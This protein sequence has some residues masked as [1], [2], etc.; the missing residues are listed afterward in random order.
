[1][2]I[3]KDNVDELYARLKTMASGRRPQFDAFVSYLEKKTVWLVSPASTRFHLSCCKGLLM[4]S[5]G[6]AYQLLTIKDELLPSVDD[7]SA[8]I[9]G[10]F[11]DVG[12]LGDPGKPLYLKGMENYYYNPQVVSMGLGVRGLYLVSQ[13]IALSPDEAQAICCHDGQYI[14][15]NE[16]VAHR[17]APLTLLLHYA[18]YW[19]A[20][21]YEDEARWRR[22][23]KP[24]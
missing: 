4:H 24:E 3:T 19:Q 9:C 23:I 13:H 21:M 7:E 10:L 5:V 16:V 17:E 15:E 12:K 2:R 6:V 11:H 14:P 18:D 8:V 1:M 22:Y 20:H